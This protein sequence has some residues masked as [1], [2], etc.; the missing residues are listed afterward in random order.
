[1]NIKKRIFNFICF[2][3]ILPITVIFTLAVGG[4]AIFGARSILDMLLGLGMAIIPWVWLILAYK[5]LLK[6][7]DDKEIN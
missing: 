6:I 2:F 3:V 5:Y 4:E 7:F 1:M